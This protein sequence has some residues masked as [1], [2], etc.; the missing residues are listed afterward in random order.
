MLRGRVAEMKKSRQ[1][2]CKEHGHGHGRGQSKQNSEAEEQSN[3][4]SATLEEVMKV[5]GNVVGYAAAV[6][7]QSG[8]LDDVE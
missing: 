3:E 2:T 8:G 5:S 6:S 4:L 7:E 1:H